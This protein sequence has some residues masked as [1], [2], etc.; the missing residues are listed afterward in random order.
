MCSD[1]LINYFTSEQV[2]AFQRRIVALS[3]PKPE[4]YHLVDMKN[5]TNVTHDELER[6]VNNYLTDKNILIKVLNWLKQNE[7]EYQNYYH[8]LDIQFDYLDIRKLNI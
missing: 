2:L 7:D 5:A 3:F 1:K 4:H 6:Y 8:R